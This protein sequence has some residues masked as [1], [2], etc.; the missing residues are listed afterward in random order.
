MTELI[1]NNKNF[2]P[3]KHTI[4]GYRIIG[5]EQRG[6]DITKLILTDCASKSEESQTT[7]VQQ[8]KGEM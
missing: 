6:D 3:T 7:A 4:V 2:T 8:A 1:I 5:A